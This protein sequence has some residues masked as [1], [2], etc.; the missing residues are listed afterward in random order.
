M[1]AALIAIAVLLAAP[2]QA[3]VLGIHGPSTHFRD[4]PNNANLGLYVRSDGIEMGAYYNSRRKP[5]L[6]AGRMWESDWPLKPAVLVGVASG[7]DK[8]L[9]P[10]VIP[11]VS[12]PVMGKAVRVALIPS[13]KK[14]LPPAVHLS[15]EHAF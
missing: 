1:K 3:D 10:F 4:G 5:T 11:S 7:Y 9:T 6:Y 13:I 2:A 12:V 8:L 14:G 15:I